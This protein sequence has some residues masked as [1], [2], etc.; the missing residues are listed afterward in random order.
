M[1]KP[2]YQTPYALADPEGGAP[3]ARPPNGRGTM[4]F[5]AQNAN[6]SQ[7]FLRSLIYFK[8]NFNRN[9]AK[10]RYHLSPP[11]PPL[12]KSTRPLRTNPGSATVMINGNNLFV[13]SFSFKNVFLLDLKRIHNLVKGVTTWKIPYDRKNK[14][15][16]EKTSE[17][18]RWRCYWCVYNKE[19]YLDMWRTG[20][21]TDTTLLSSRSL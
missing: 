3:G 4:I 18:I 21:N 1:S 14:V 12:T 15:V 19:I 5:Y 7:F 2:L 11:L 9:M 16:K 8:H 13:K 10:T 17:Q 20:P 6:F